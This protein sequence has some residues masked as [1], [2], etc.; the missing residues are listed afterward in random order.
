M[1]ELNPDLLKTAFKGLGYAWTDDR[2]NLIG[3]RRTELAPDMFND[4]FVIVW[5]QPVL[6]ATN[7]TTL[8]KQKAL[9]AWLYKG[10]DGKPLTT[11]GKKGKNT[12]YAE[13]DYNRTVGTYRLRHW[14]I[15]TVPGIYYLE[16]PSNSK[17]TAVFKP[18]QYLD[19][20]SFGYHKQ[21]TDHPALLQTKNIVVYRDIDKDKYAEETTTLD[22]GLFGC[23]IHRSNST[24]ATATIGKWGAGCQVFQVKSDH[25]V[26]LA[27]IKTYIGQ[28]IKNFTYTLLREKE[29]G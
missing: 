19:A 13:D 8:E 9:N 23:N 5:K 29:L 1:R 15:T 2:P 28:G 4:V 3:I 12:A 17:G 16:N 6:F 10:E 14:A 21:K 11:D 24:G 26:L 20:Y 25:D 18:G 7:A 22:T 27:L